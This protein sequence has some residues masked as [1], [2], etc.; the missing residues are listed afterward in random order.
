[1]NFKTLFLCAGL[2]SLAP[3]LVNAG[4]TDIP[5]VAESQPESQ[6]LSLDKA[7]GDA[8]VR[9]PRLK[10]GVEG[11]GASRGDRTQSGLI[12]N[13]E[14]SIE[15]ENVFG[16]GA[17]SGV[18]GAEMTVGVQQ[19]IELGGKRSARIKAADYRGSIAQL[20]YQAAGLDLVRDVTVSWV[21][22]VSAAEEV[23]LAEEQ[24]KLATEVLESVARRVSAAAEPA[25]QKS[26][27]EV[28]LASSKIELRKA[29]KNLA[30]AMKNLTLLVLLD[31]SD[32]T[33]DT[34]SFFKVEK[35][36]FKTELDSLL[37]NP[38]VQKLKAGVD[39]ASANI[40][41][42]KS[43]AVPDVTVG[44]GIKDSRESGD[45]SFV[46]GLT[47]PFPVFNRNQGA[48]L[49]AGH[50]A[51]KAAHEKA[52]A[53]NDIQ[54]NVIK[55][56]NVLET[57]YNE[58][59]SL[60]KDILP[61]ADRA[62]SQARQGYKAGKFPYLE[63]LDAQRTL[64]DVR[65]QRITATREYRIARAEFDRLTGRNINIVKNTGENQ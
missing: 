64:F 5:L 59:E 35:P 31:T 13:P 36:D 3:T 17:A 39:L 49:K 52:S 48:I 51:A 34:S 7:I 10:A 24:N 27:A 62:F 46:A 33:L 32:V 20:E 26:K 63:V 65:K 9:S 45:Q 41:I 14:F 6:A 2:L 21:E 37:Q 28:A 16:T 23:K 38:D 1:M 29:E 61:S 53:E 47:I 54:L 22:A 19:P 42:E 57:S 60:E 58:V 4:Q 18:G 12:P 50:E 11:I 40:D 8:L 55:A 30:S 15:A 25:I 44:V 43:N 56:K